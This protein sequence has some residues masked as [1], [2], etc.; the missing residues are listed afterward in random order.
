[1][2]QSDLLQ[3][4]FAPVV[5]SAMTGIATAVV[6]LQMVLLLALGTSEEAPQEAY[7]SNDVKVLDKWD[8]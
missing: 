3:N 5:S 2:C 8:I 4:E 1:M 6:S 7:L